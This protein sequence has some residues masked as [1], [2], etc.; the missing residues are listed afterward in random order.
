VIARSHTDV[1]G[2]ATLE[3]LLGEPPSAGAHRLG[4]PVV[5]AGDTIVL[6]GAG[7]IGRTVLRK[8]RGI[9]IEPAVFAVDTPQRPSVDGLP[10]LTPRQAAAAFDTR[11]VFIVAMLNPAVRFIEASQRLGAI[12]PHAHIRSF[13]HLA[14]Q[15]PDAFLPY[16][17]IDRPERVLAA[18]PAI[19]RAFDLWAD[20]ESRRQFLAH[21]RFRLQLD[22]AALPRPTGEGYFPS[23]IVPALPENTT[24]V[25]GGAYDGDTIRS[26]LARQESRFEAIH[27]FEP[28]P[29]NYARLAAFVEGLPPPLAAR[30]RIHAAAV[31]NRAGV[32]RFH[33]TGDRSAS[34]AVDGDVDVRVVRIDD[35]IDVRDAPAYL[36]LDVEGGERDALEGAARLIAGGRTRLAVSVYHRPADLWELPAVIAALHPGARLWL[37][38]EG[39]DGTDAVCFA[40]PAP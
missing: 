39:E 24:F 34:A 30:I 29:S 16:V 12:A 7:V 25:D 33:A 9:G 32:V 37:R 13:A 3:A 8:L 5:S 27:A 26:F 19:R 14:W 1:A 15:F 18:A 38:T 11:L 36:K 17:H 21:L 23:D 40:V 28:D 20:A 35:A 22:F 6:Y 10:V 4:S 2:A 31:G